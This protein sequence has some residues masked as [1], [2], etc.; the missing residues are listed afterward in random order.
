M[1]TY[2]HLYNDTKKEEVHWNHHIK[3]GPI[4]LNSTVHCA[5]VN[6][7]FV[8]QGDRLRFMGDY[9]AEPENYKEVNL[10]DY[11]FESELAADAM[12]DA[13]T[14]EYLKGAH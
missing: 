8:N 3:E 6:Y 11:H 5:L 2:Y 1:G 10:N 9:G 7:M 12:K 14:H 13:I 4:C